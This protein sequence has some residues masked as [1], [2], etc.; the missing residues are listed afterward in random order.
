MPRAAGLTILILVAAALA[1]GACADSYK[2]DGNVAVDQST[3]GN[4]PLAI[5]GGFRKD[6]VEDCG[7]DCQTNGRPSAG[8]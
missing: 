1:T 5:D 6:N 8:G 4:A 2:F 7:D 3:D